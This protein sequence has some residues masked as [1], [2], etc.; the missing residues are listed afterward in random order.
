[1]PLRFHLFPLILSALALLGAG[2]P[3]G[4][5]VLSATAAGAGDY[6]LTSVTVSRDGNNFTYTPAQLTGGDLT[7]IDA[8]QLPILVQS[9]ASL[10]ASGTRATL[11]EDNRL[12]T[13]IINIT[14][15]N[16]TPD[17]SAELTFNQP[18]VNSDDADI[19]LFDVAGTDGIRWWINDDRTSQSADLLPASN[20]PALLSG[21]P[22]TLYQ[23]SNPAQSN[24][25]LSLS[26]LESDS[27]NFS[28][29]ANSSGTVHALELDLSTVGV[30]IG[31]SVSSIRFQT[32][33]GVTGAGTGRI[34]PV[35]VVGLP[36]VPEPSG[37]TFIGALLLAGAAQRSQRTQRCQEVR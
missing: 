15:T 32:L 14:T 20:S 16:G 33:T 35:M 23:Y 7:D 11:L 22:F 37:V 6:N 2:S 19:L 9:G 25:I 10:P 28:F 34:D 4:A 3:C 18:V 36:A 1:M 26:D 12:D 27:S 21:M 29:S 24:N 8:Y 13:G 31:G 17:R 30:P 5:S